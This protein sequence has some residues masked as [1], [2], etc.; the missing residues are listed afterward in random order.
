MHAREWSCDRTVA[1]RESLPG[2]VYHTFTPFPEGVT[3]GSIYSATGGACTG[4][5][6]KT[7][8]PSKMLLPSGRSGYTAVTFGGHSAVITGV[9]RRSASRPCPQG[10]RRASHLW[11]MCGKVQGHVH[12][13]ESPGFSA[14]GAGS[15][16]LFW[17]PNLGLLI[18]PWFALA[19]V[20]GRQP[21]VLACLRDSVLPSGASHS[22]AEA[23]SISRLTTPWTI[24]V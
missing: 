2:L 10:A 19:V 21:Y 7:K 5:K 20:W 16:I 17:W 22:N 11:S 18:L 4:H 24:G 1:G 14:V 8:L 23:L 3:E 6:E 12:S 9:H 13:M 15:K